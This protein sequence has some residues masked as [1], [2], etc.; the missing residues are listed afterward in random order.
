MNVTGSCK[1]T[2][3]R[4]VF[5]NS[6]IYSQLPYNISNSR[7]EIKFW[8]LKDTNSC[9][10][11]MFQWCSWQVFSLLTPQPM[12][13]S[14]WVHFQLQQY[15]RFHTICPFVWRHEQ[16]L[17]FL[18]HTAMITNLNGRCKSWQARQTH[19][20]LPNN[21]PICSIL[22]LD[23]QSGRWLSHVWHYK[24]NLHWVWYPLLIN[25]PASLTLLMDFSPE[26]GGTT[27]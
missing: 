12:V 18:F 25:F 13:Q 5:S 26:W 1:Y 24:V 21:R 15:I 3:A 17:I 9:V 16:S 8:V 2:A 11:Y 22:L 20:I 10:W 27:D 6:F 14:L 4:S 7:F 19:G 23:F